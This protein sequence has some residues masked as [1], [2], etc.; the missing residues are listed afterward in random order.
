MSTKVG[1]GVP[2]LIF[3]RVTRV[4]GVNKGLLKIFMNFGFR[5]GDCK[6]LDKIAKSL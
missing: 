2:K 5:G 1:A 6:V 3:E 4:E